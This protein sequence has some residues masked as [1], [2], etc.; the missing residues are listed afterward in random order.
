MTR[1]KITAYAKINLVLDVL[2]KREDG[3]HEVSMV[4][5][6]IDLADTIFFGG[7]A[8]KLVGNG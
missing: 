5:Q 1:A 2:R 4:M 8:A 7:S 3:Y 6:A